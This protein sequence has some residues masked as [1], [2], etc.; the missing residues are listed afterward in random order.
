MYVSFEENPAQLSPH[1]RALGTDPDEAARDGLRILYVSPVELQIDSI[2]DTVFNAIREHDVRR[3][4][5]DAVGDLLG[6]ASDLQ[7][8]HGYLYALAQHFAVQG[9]S[10]IFTYETAASGDVERRLSALADNILLIGVELAERRGL[11]TLR[12]VKARGIAHDLD[13]HELRISG[14]GAEVG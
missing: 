9:V 11:R 14:K 12:V 13:V 3:V 6:A 1:I 4:V 2:I 10:S 7:R 8:L 5:I